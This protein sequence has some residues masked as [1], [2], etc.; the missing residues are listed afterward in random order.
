VGFYD[1]VH[2]AQP[3]PGTFTRRFGGEEGLKNPL[4]Q[5]WLD[6]VAEVLYAKHHIGCML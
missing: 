1:T 4:L 3:K 5:V 6:T 2:D